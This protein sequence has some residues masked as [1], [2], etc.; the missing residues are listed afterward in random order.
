MKGEPFHIEIEPTNI[1][2]TRCLHCPHEALARPMGKMDW[3]TYQLVLDKVIAYAPEFSVE[4]AG[5]GE[6][7]L[8]PEIY[9]F[10]ATVSPRAQTTMT[11]NASAL[12][13][14][15]V[16]RLI[17]AGL[18]RLT[19]S[20]NG[21][22]PIIYELMMGGLSF[23]RAEKNLRAAIEMTSKT[24]T[25][26]VANV[27]VTRQTQDR[28]AD[29]KAYLQTAG[30]Q[31]IYFSKCHSRGGFLKGDVVCTTPLPTTDM[32]RCDIFTETLFIAWTGEVLTCCHALAGANVLG[33]L[34]AE[35][36]EDILARKQ[37]HAARGIDFEI[38]GKCNDLYRFMNDATPDGRTISDW[39]YSLY[40]N[41]ATADEDYVEP[42]PLV[43]WLYRVYAAE[44]QGEGFFGS[45]TA[46]AAAQERNVKAQLAEQQRQ[47]ADLQHQIEDIHAG[48]A[49]KLAAQLRKARLALIPEGSS[50]ETLFE[51]LIKKP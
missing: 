3:E 40:T 19:V 29:I 51:R 16:E 28:L 44:G 41:P 20:F 4:Y 13:Q 7:L 23:E 48:Q 17:E 1:C 18:S 26:V 15:N 35:A 50:R 25:R 11:T 37:Q 27:S 45:I 47:I 24:S 42:G 22:D 36:L 14:R 6:P 39:V 49:W 43:E 34:K 32:G 9:R 2:N 33:D 12:T 38:C 31:D 5:M 10:I 30:V 21:D 8:N 46:Q